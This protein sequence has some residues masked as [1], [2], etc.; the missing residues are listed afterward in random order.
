M[1]VQPF[2][3]PSVDTYAYRH[4]T[5]CNAL[6]AILVHDPEAEKAAAACDVSIVLVFVFR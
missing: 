2:K 3:I 5:L 6:E 1:T 4:V